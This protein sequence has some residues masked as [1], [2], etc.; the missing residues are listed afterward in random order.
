MAMVFGRSAIGPVQRERR[1]VDQT[2]A[3]GGTTH[4]AMRIAP[5]VLRR[6]G[7]AGAT[8]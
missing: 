7:T 8:K 1:M 3:P 5:P 4:N 6:M 2:P